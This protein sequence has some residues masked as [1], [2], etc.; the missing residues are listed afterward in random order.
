MLIQDQCLN[1]LAEWSKKNEKMLS[2]RC[3]EKL[4]EV[5]QNG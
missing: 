3:G 5:T 2:E 4:Y 1:G